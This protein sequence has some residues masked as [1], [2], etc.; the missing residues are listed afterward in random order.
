MLRRLWHFW[1]EDYKIWHEFW[2]KDVLKA[3]TEKGGMSGT[4]PSEKKNLAIHNNF[5]LF[6]SVSVL[7]ESSK[8]DCWMLS[9][10]WFGPFQ[11]QKLCPFVKRVKNLWIF[12][13][14]KW[15]NKWVSLTT[16]PLGYFRQKSSLFNKLLR[17]GKQLQCF[18]SCKRQGWTRRAITMQ[19]SLMKSM[20]ISWNG[21]LNG[22]LFSSW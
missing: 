17:N 9:S 21:F 13:Q 3:D 6:R 20:P 16:N 1:Y 11:H 7:C 22:F 10:I 18:L 2:K 8:T 14:R 15:G 12:K 4:S 5:R 19:I